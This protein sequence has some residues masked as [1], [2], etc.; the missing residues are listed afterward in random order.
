MRTMKLLIL[1]VA[2]LAGCMQVDENPKWNPKAEYPAWAYDAPQYYRPTED[3]QVAE[4]LGD[5]IPVYYT[6]SEYFFVRHP[7]GYQ[8]TGESRVAVWCSTDQGRRWE[9]VG[10]YGVEQSHFLFKAEADGEHWIRFVG[11]GQGVTDVPPGMP[12][13]IYAVDTRS[14]AIQVAVKPGP[15]KDRDKK[16]P[17]IYRV[18]ETVTL[19]W[20]VVDPYLAPRSI[21]VGTCFAKFPYNLV[22]NRIPGSLPPK[23][24]IDVELPPE[25]A[26]EGGIRFRVEAADKAGNAGVGLTDVLTVASQKP[27]SQPTT[28]PAGPF[29]LVLQNEG[30][31]ETKPGWPMPGALLRGG[32]VRILDWLPEQ[33][34]KYDTLELE[35]SPNNGQMWQ[36]VATGLKVGRP[37]R[38]TVPMVTSKNCLLRIV[39]ITRGE[40]GKEPQKFLLAQTQ[41][42][43]VD[44]V[45][46]DSIVPEKPTLILPE[47]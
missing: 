33:A 20:T 38:W 35:F 29:E 40:P 12:H 6:R 4:T 44:T 42:F 46:P 31:K 41:R 27:T 17:Y 37:A 10:Y 11:P 5:G 23:Y 43:T 19:S 13:R 30:A 34:A 36:T 2:F 18:G 39:A 7:G 21:G 47:K 8:L 9:K 26:R 45:V 3:L 1:G 24:S 28:R 32:A 25:A 16:V 22:W 14:P 15:W